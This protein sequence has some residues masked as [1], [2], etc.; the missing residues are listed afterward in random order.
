MHCMSIQI[1]CVFPH[2][3]TIRYVLNVFFAFCVLF[4]IYTLYYPFWG[5]SELMCMCDHKVSWSLE[6]GDQT[7]WQTTQNTSAQSACLDPV[8]LAD[9]QTYHVYVRASDV[10]NNTVTDSV[11]FH[12]DGTGPEV[13]DLGLRNRWGR[14]GVHVHA[15]ADLSTMV[16]VLEASDPHSGLKALRWSL[17]TESLTDDVG[18]RAFAV[19]RIENVVRRRDT[20]G[21][22]LSLIS[23]RPT[24]HRPTSCAQS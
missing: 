19:Q 6:G 17:G 23:H 24:Y 21:V 1:I 15:S 5:H 20:R 12:V 11:T 8:T 13:Q 18:S 10:M 7:Q 22:I 14:D 16:L 2:D 9:G 3:A 4:V